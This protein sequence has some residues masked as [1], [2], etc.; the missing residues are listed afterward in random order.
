MDLTL[1]VAE[2]AVLMNVS[3]AYVVKLIR[4]GKLPASANANGT[5]TVARRD[6][7]AYRL[8]AKRHGRKALEEL[9]RQSQE[10]GLYDKQR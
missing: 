7:E 8:K 2:A 10:V 6:A 4:D 3:P 1:T 9:A 5:H